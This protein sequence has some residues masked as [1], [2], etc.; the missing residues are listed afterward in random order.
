MRVAN[1]LK[2]DIKF[3]VK[4]GFYGVYIVLTIVY[5]VILSAI[6]EEIRKILIPLIVFSD[7]SI[8]GFFF[9][10]GIIMLEKGQGILQYLAVTPL[11]LKEYIL[12]KVISLSI[13]AVLAGFMITAVTYRGSV[14]WIL[15]FLGVFLSSAFCTLLGFGVGLRSKTINEYFIKM[16]PGMLLIAVPCFSLLISHPYGIVFNIFPSVSGL[17][18]VYG[19]YQ[20]IAPLELVGNSIV[21]MFFTIIAL[22]WIEKLMI[23]G[24][25]Q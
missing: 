14:N 16:I 23:R 25:S 4:Q 19:A 8:V 5:M 20:G 7:P 22:N 3:Q 9:I 17:K 2:A 10:G 13:L 6:P 12:G 24:E 1:A 15:L 11:R 21:L 18:L